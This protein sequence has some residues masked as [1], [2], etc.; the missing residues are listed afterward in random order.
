MWEQP[1]KAYCGLAMDGGFRAQQVWQVIDQL[2]ERVQALSSA[3]PTEEAAGYGAK[4]GW[5][6]LS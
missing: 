5:A 3:A 1:E 2:Q 6:G 4:R